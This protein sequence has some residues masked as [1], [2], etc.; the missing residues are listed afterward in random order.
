MPPQDKHYRTLLRIKRCFGRLLA[1]RVAEFWRRYLDYQNPRVDAATE[2]LFGGDCGYLHCT[3]CKYPYVPSKGARHNGC[4]VEHEAPSQAFA[5]EQDK[6]DKQFWELVSPLICGVEDCGNLL[7]PN[8]YGMCT[9]HFL[10]RYCSKCNLQR[11]V[12]ACSV[13]PP[14]ESLGS[15]WRQSQ[16]KPWWNG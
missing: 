7:I 3:V 14:Q 16:A 9:G 5:Q 11:A 15:L 8:G 12:C 10:G 13:S 6:F 2:Y 1:Y 4:L